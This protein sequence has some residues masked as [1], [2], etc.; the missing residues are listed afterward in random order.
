VP[1]GFT[2]LKVV[3]FCVPLFFTN[4]LCVDQALADSDLL[5]VVLDLFFRYEWNNFLHQL[6]ESLVASLFDASSGPLRSA[7]IVRC[8]LPSRLAKAASV[9]E[10]RFAGGG[11]RAGNHAFLLLLGETLATAGEADADIAALLEK[12]EGW[13]AF[14]EGPLR[15]SRQMADLAQ[16][17]SDSERDSSDGDLGAQRDAQAFTFGGWQDASDS[18][19]EGG[20]SE[21]DVDAA[22]QQALEELRAL[23]MTAQKANDN[24]AADP[25][26]GEEDAN[27]K[28][29]DSKDSDEKEDGAGEGGAAAK[30]SSDDDAKSGNED[31]A[32]DTKKE[33]GGEED[34]AD[35]TDEGDETK[36][37][38]ERADTGAPFADR[39]AL[40]DRFREVGNNY[41]TPPPVAREDHVHAHNE[42]D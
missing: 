33:D 40:G 24:A 26:L 39:K 27:S 41:G 36:P 2:R 1:L 18:S 34:D 13:K 4:R 12:E 14:E 10:E 30:K 28:G 9:S 11:L 17:D 8:H 16:L 21:G 7:A 29:D 15:E 32:G 38:L 35:K 22:A 42:D 3:Q 25:Q 31:A 37:K 19:E 20:S 6:V 5:S 23:A